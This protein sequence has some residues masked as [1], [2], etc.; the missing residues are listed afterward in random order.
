M[1]ILIF[2]FLFI[3]LSSCNEQMKT[4]LTPK[5][6][7]FGKMNSIVVLA[8]KNIIDSPVKD[9]LEMYFE[10]S[11]PVMPAPEPMFDLRYMTMDDLLTDKLKKELRTYLVLVNLNDP[12]SP[13][14]RMIQQD[15]GP[16]KFRQVMEEGKNNI[17][18]GSNKWAQGQIIIYLMGKGMDGLVNAIRAQYPNVAKKFNDHDEP[19]LHANLY[20]SAGINNGG[21]EQIKSQ[22]GIDLSLPSTFA[23]ANTV[24]DDNILWYVRNLK[25]LTQHI[26]VRKFS[27]T[28]QKQFSKDSII[29]MRDT[30]GAKYISSNIEGSYM[31][32]QDKEL[33]VFDYS[34]K[35]DNAFAR[36]VRGVWELE[37][38]FKGGPFV[39]FLI[40]N[41]KKNEVIFIDGFVFGPGATKREA[42]QQ[43]AYI[44][45]KAKIL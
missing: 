8:D 14:S 35:V 3:L 42:I 10:S 25:E 37:N 22:F 13:V 17:A 21:N 45:K 9:S 44:V 20:G 16:E 38:D 28:S 7:A 23:K 11:Y 5:P 4:N 33:P 31:V 32:T 41:E 18:Y 15:L 1:R 24:D 29:Q 36:E 2:G 12:N 39:T 19:Q 6:K 30:Y 43:L 27:Y 40:H 26:V 34:A